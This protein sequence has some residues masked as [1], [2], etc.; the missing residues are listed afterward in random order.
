V[1]EACV[2]GRK[3]RSLVFFAFGSRNVLCAVLSLG[4]LSSGVCLRCMRLGG[5]V[6]RGRSR[7]SWP[8]LKQVRPLE[9][10]RP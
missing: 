10:G 9:R 1:G 8:D 7:S 3:V 2:M 4:R 6:W 5:A